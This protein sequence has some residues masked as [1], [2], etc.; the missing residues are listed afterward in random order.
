MFV[1]QDFPNGGEPYKFISVGFPR[2]SIKR[3]NKEKYLNE[4]NVGR[5]NALGNNEFIND[6]LSI[7]TK[8]NKYGYI[9]V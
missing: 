3:L 8:F 4:K 7:I 1:L 2:L 5:G 9:I 6:S